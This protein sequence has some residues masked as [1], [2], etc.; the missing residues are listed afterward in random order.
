[1]NAFMDFYLARLKYS[2]QCFL[3]H[4]GKSISVMNANY[5]FYYFK[6]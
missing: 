1:M 6:L 3:P 5:Y 2:C 4:F